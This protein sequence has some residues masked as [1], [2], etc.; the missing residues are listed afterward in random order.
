MLNIKNLSLTIENR[1]LL[2]HCNL[3]ASPGTITAIT[4]PSGSG[5]TS[6]LEILALLRPPT[7]GTVTL[8]KTPLRIDQGDQ[9]R[10]N[11]ISFVHQH[12][13]FIHGLSLYENLLFPTLFS[14]KKSNVAPFIRNAFATLSIPTRWE[15]DPTTLS[16]GEQQRACL[17]RGLLVQPQLCLIDEPT[18]NLDAATTA[19]TLAW[20]QEIFQENKIIAIIATHDPQVIQQS[21][22]HIL[23][24]EQCS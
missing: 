10:G 14:D 7:K 4:G 20:L 22:H 21:D 12:P 11:K 2:T 6:F 13:H 3:E 17:V 18:A 16:G 19:K 1:T 5:K 24:G 9:L 8:H 15:D 23:L